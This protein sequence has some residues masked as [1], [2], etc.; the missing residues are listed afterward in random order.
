MN[1]EEKLQVRQ[2][3]LDWAIEKLQRAKALPPDGAVHEISDAQDILSTVQIVN[4]QAGI[5]RTR[6]M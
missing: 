6:E 3:L 2:T 1:K 5:V 4:R